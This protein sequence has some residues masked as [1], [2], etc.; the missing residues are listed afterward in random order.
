M[1]FV[2]SHILDN[3]LQTIS[4]KLDLLTNK[5]FLFLDQILALKFNKTT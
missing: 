2:D 3:Y 5:I 1:K 4:K